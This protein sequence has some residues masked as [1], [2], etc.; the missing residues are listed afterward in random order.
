LVPIVSY[1]ALAGKCR[2]CGKKISWQYPAVEF[3]TGALFVIT[4]FAFHGPT[5]GPEFWYFLFVLSVLI[6]IF[7]TDFRDGLIPDK[8]ILPALVIALALKLVFFSFPISHIPYPIPQLVYDIGAGFGAG[9][10]FYLLIVISKGKGIG[11]GDVKYAAFLGF[12]LGTAKVITALFLA[13]LTGAAFATILILV[14]KKRFGQTVPFGPFLSI[15]AYFAL[16][17]GQQILDW[18]LRINR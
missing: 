2:Y 12:A 13:F 16:I 10:F 7:I 1:L 6:V 11:G 9:A 3:S 18:Y 14:G 5:F 8:V 4:F 17:W 15:G